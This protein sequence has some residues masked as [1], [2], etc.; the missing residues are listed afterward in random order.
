M[1]RVNRNALA[2]AGAIAAGLVFAQGDLQPSG[3][4]GPEMRSLAELHERAAETARH[5][6]IVTN[7][8][9]SLHAVCI[10][11]WPDHPAAQANDNLV[12]LTNV[13]LGVDWPA[14][15]RFDEDL[16]A[17][18]NAL[19]LWADWEDVRAIHGIVIRIDEVL[20][21]LLNPHLIT[22][23]LCGHAVM[24]RQI[25]DLFT[26]TSIISGQLSRVAEEM[27]TIGSTAGDNNAM[28]RQ[29]TEER[30]QAAEP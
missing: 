14:L 27:A 11:P 2:A 21:G 12:G 23:N 25:T 20:A 4:P 30:Q 22:N 28:L 1:I 19:L 5:T 16:G 15:E 8:L 13:L 18:T 24:E 9:A 26:A 3:P 29:L 10:A 6:G 7:A 17:L